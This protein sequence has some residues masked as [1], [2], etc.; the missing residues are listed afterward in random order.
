VGVNATTSATNDSNTANN[1][2]SATV[3]LIDAVSDATVT[4][5]STTSAQTV[6]GSVL[7]NDTVGAVAATSSNVVVQ[8]ILTVTGGPTTTGW[9]IDSAGLVTAPA[10]VAAGNYSIAYTI[11]SNPA[12]TPAACDSAVKAVTVNA[13]TPADLTPTFSFGGT[14]YVVNQTR[15]VIINIIEINNVPTTGAVQFFVPLPGGVAF[16]DYTFDPMATSAPTLS[17]NPL[18]NNGDWTAQTT[19]TGLLF[20]LDSTKVIAGG[21][22]SRIVIKCTARDPAAKSNLT[23]N[24]VANSGGETRTNN[25]VVV[26]SQS[27]QR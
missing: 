27:V 16:D 11:C 19:G 2:A 21:T 13:G 23:V 9:T 4:I 17:G 10:N 15:E 3:A 1:A 25:N 26:L 7:S 12:V 24:I 22:R 14:S 6:S 5:T 8:S 18:V 20:T